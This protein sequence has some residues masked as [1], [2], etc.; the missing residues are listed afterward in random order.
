MLRHRASFVDKQNLLYRLQWR[1]GH[2][3]CRRAF[4]STRGRD[5]LNRFP[6]RWV[7]N[8]LCKQERDGRKVHTKR[9][10][11]T[12]VLRATSHSA[13]ANNE[14]ENMSAISYHVTTAKERDVYCK[15][16]ASKAVRP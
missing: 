9:T 16:A 1:L 14:I 5:N 3:S 6:V 10:E 11:K 8:R 7:N 12:R 15:R 4:H 13:D 2:V